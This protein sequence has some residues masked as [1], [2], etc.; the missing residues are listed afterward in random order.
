MYF[1]CFHMVQV[2][3][4]VPEYYHKR[5]GSQYYFLT[6]IR[7]MS[8]HFTSTV[9]FWFLRDSSFEVKT[10]TAPIGFPASVCQN[11]SLRLL[12]HIVLVVP[13]CSKDRHPLAPR[14]CPIR[15]MFPCLSKASTKNAQGSMVRSTT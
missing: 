12:F 10:L 3:A 13:R 8:H 2:T 7:L 9:A 1:F 14:R 11:C 4:H 5:P 6:F 15:K